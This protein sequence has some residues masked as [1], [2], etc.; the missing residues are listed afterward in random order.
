M[1]TRIVYDRKELLKVCKTFES[2]K[3]LCLGSFKANYKDVTDQELAD[4]WF[5]LSGER[6]KSKTTSEPKADGIKS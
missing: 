4:E 1:S 3:A 6:I 5:Y 2:F